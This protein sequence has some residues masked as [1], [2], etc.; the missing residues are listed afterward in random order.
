MVIELLADVI[1]AGF[2]NNDGGHRW[3]ATDVRMSDGRV[4]GMQSLLEPRLCGLR[5][6]RGSKT[7]WV[8]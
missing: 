2:L 5:A 1:D 8:L 6:L 4:E 3:S 7:A